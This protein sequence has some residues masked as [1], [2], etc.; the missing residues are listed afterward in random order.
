MGGGGFGQPSQLG[1][2]SPAAGHQFGSVVAGGGLGGASFGALA[3]SSSPSP[4]GS[5]GFGGTNTTHFGSSAP[6]G[7]GLPSASPFGPP[8]R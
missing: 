4:F 5:P 2:S 6:Q 1:S 8:R 7:F 3:Q